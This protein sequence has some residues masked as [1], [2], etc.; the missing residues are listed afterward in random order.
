M[1]QLFIQKAY[2]NGKWENALDQ[3]TIEVINPASQQKLGTVPKMGEAETAQ[4]VEAAYIYN[5]D[6]I[7]GNAGKVKLSRFTADLILQD[8]GT[9][10][11]K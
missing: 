5:F 7:N 11:A 1:N 6:N 3:S 2:I 4:A 8:L 10:S 9:R